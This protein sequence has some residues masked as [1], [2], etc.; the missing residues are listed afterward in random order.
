MINP[1]ELMIGNYLH[2]NKGRLCR[3]EKI[4]KDSFYAPAIDGA[5]TSAPNHPIPLT[6]SILERYGFVEH[7]S[8]LYCHSLLIGSIIIRT[9]LLQKT[10]LILSIEDEY[11]QFITINNITTLHHL[12]N[13]VKNLTGKEL[14]VKK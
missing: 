3:V 9:D 14:E 6:P 8:S 4:E 1:K 12:Q 11:N 5:I 7:D 2:D 10:T 13:I